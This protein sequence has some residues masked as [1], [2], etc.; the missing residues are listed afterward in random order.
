MPNSSRRAR[1]RAHYEPLAQAGGEAHQ[2]LDWSSREAQTARFQVLAD[3]CRRLPAAPAASIPSL[4]DVGCGLTDLK[5]Y[6]DAH[7]IPT[8]YAG[9]D[10]T[11]AILEVARQRHPCRSM[12]LADIF[13]AAPFAP[14]TFDLVFC[15]GTLNLRLDNNHQFAE[16]ALRAMLGLSRRLLVVN[17][18][19]Q[20]TQVQYL[21]CFYYSPTLIL[22]LAR[23]LAP[24]NA[25][26]KLV[27]DYLD[28]D[29]SIEI[30]LCPP[31]TNGTSQPPHPPSE[32]LP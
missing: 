13:Q 23:R 21:H 31:P 1:I 26:C 3:A 29:F 14:Q 7:D 22:E 12:L 32:T 6:L 17:F 15:S 30:Q 25:T 10:L 8:R 4:L 27:D 20:R 9:V 18:L 2:I 28:N 19:H 24:D 11:P 5:S 16:Q